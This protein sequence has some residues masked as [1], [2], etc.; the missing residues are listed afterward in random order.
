[1][2]KKSDEKWVIKDNLDMKNFKQ[3][4]PDPALHFNFE[5]KESYLQT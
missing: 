3:L 1:M 2:A 4:I 5:L